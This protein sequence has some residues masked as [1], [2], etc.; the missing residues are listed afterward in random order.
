M[1]HQRSSPQ[2]IILLSDL[3]TELPQF[4]GQRVLVDLF[5]EAVSQFAM[6]FVEGVQNQVGDVGMLA[7]ELAV[8]HGWAF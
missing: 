2:L 4:D 6:R 1:P 7:L 8:G 5:I 3:Q